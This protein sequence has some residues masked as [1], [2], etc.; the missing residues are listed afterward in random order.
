MPRP[1]K[2]TQEKIDA[3]RSDYELFPE[4][5]AAKI[6]EMH[7]VSLRSV[8]SAVRGIRRNGVK[9]GDISLDSLQV[10]GVQVDQDKNVY[11]LHKPFTYGPLNSLERQAEPEKSRL[12]RCPEQNCDYRG[13][14]RNLLAHLIDKHA[15]EDLYY[16]QDI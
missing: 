10:G 12:A 5:T 2:L 13:K 8:E 9:V 7:K 1:I 4:W 3:I 14:A 11:G 15:R 6:A 16:L